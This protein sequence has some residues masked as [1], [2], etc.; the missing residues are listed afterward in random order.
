MVSDHYLLPLMYF[1]I[2]FG[3]QCS[4]MA[5]RK[6]ICTVYQALIHTQYILEGYIHCWFES[7]H[8]KNKNIDYHLT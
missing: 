6:N 8:E 2:I 5:W 1:L 4:A 3:Q 7:A